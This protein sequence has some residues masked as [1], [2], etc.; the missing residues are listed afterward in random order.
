VSDGDRNGPVKLI[1]MRFSTAT[2]RRFFASC[3]IAALCCL[4]AA[5][6][7]QPTGLQSYDVELVIFRNLSPGATPEE[8]RLEAADAGLR[9]SIPDDEPSPF[10]PTTELSAPTAIF[11]ALTPTKY[12]LTAIE[13][14]LRRSRN[15]RPIAHFGWT[16]PGFP[17]NDARYFPINS[18]IPDASGL[19]GQIAL[20]RGR[21]LHLTLDLVFEPPEDGQRFVLR[22][23]RRMRSNERH[24]IDHPKF[25]VIA[26]ITPSG[27][28][29]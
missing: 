21:Y 17:R 13:E 4:G 29:Q 22:Q 6:A 2:S 27:G 26:I 8:W 5:S 14:T 20:S 15:Y 9:L 7:Q 11:P 18:M 28:D 10:A 3:A 16:Q 23:T 1:C 12:K 19:A 25:G 24:Y